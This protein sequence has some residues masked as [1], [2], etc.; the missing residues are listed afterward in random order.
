MTAD[1]QTNWLA[2]AVDALTDIRPGEVQEVSHEVRR[3]VTRHMQIIPAI[4]DAVA[5]LRKRKAE[6]AR[7]ANSKPLPPPP[8]RVD[9]GPLSPDEISR[10]PSWLKQMGMRVGFLEKRG[11]QLVDAGR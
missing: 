1:Q 3:K 5:E 9:R 10:M 8:E 2:S 7:Y 4:A 6:S 11:G